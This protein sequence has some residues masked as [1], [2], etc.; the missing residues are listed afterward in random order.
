[1]KGFRILAPNPFLL[2]VLCVLCVENLRESPM[3]SWI[4]VTVL[5]AATA[6]GCM[7]PGQR[8]EDD[9]IRDARMFNDD[10]RWGRWDILGQ[11]MTPEENALFQARKNLVDADLVIVDYEVTAVKF[12]Q[13]SEAAT[14]D[15]KLEWYKK[16]DPTVRQ[17]TLQQR[18]ELRAGRW[19]MIKQRRSRGDRFPL[20]P[21]GKAGQ[22]QQRP[23][24]D[25][26][27]ATPAPAPM[28]IAPVARPPLAEAVH[29][30]TAAW[31]DTGR[32]AV[33]ED[34]LDLRQKPT[35]AGDAAAAGSETGSR[36]WLWTGIGAVVAGGV[37]TAVLLSTRGPKRDGSC[38]SGLD[39]CIP[40]G[41]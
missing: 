10:F 8:R 32:P 28:P 35:S 31:P 30:P 3:K 37:A 13:G 39:G 40:V 21:D 15:V 29:P 4:L 33:R 18:W 34:G 2:C 16:S 27:T 38:P 36:W 17:A 22:N 23:R 26:L 41:Q 19:M 12:M 7:T 1:M 24:R 6:P 20:V 14:V 5:L 9:L 25:P 11:S